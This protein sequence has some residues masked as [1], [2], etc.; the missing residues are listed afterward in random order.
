MGDHA[1]RHVNDD[2]F[3]QS[4][5][6]NWTVAVSDP[7]GVVA[8]CDRVAALLAEPEVAHLGAVADDGSELTIAELVTLG[9]RSATVVRAGIDAAVLN[10]DS[11]EEFVVAIGRLRVL[12]AWM[13]D[14][15][16]GSAA[17]REHE[18]MG[19]LDRLGHLFDRAT[20]SI[21]ATVVPIDGGRFRLRWTDADR[22]LAATL[23][24]DLDALLDSDDPGIVRLFPPAYGDDIERSRGY[25]ALARGELIESRRATLAVLNRALDVPELGGDELAALM[26]AVNDLRLVIG[27][28]LDIR[29]DDDPRRRA[30]G[31]D[32][33]AWAAYERLT[34]LLSDIIDALSG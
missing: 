16:A 11:F 30:P 27:T 1:T 3:E 17:E 29:D 24:A 34:H 22:S 8:S 26:R 18:L 28:R 12:T 21:Y 25:D 4:A 14:A 20:R 23:A 10:E 32:A 19:L 7:A 31:P 6:G 9:R 2:R 33:A 15:L 5:D 13:L